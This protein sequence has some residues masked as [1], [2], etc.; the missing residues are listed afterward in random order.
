[1]DPNDGS[2]IPTDLAT[3]S[4]LTDNPIFSSVEDRLGRVNV[5][6]AFAK[7]VRALDV[8]QGA[9]VGVMA[10]WGSGKSSFVNLMRE[11]FAAE[12]TVTTIDF[13]PWMFSG[14]QQLVD[15]FFREIAAALRN[16]SAS[17]FGKVADWLDE[18]GDELGAVAALGG[19]LGSAI[20]ATVRLGGAEY[21]RRSQTG[22]VTQQRQ[23]IADDLKQLPQPIVVVVDDID[24]LGTD[25][26]RDIFKLVRLTASFPNLVYLL[27][28]DRAR[29]EAALDETNVPGRAYLEK[30]VQLSFDLPDVPI[31]LLRQELFGRLDQ[32]MNDTID[33]ARFDPAR[34]SDVFVEI[35]APL[36]T[37]LRD[38]TRFAISLRPTVAALGREVQ[39]VD[40]LALEAVRVFR[41]ELFAQLRTMRIALTETGSAWGSSK[42]DTHQE[43]ITA[44]LASAGADEPLIR[45]LILR[46]FPAATRY[47]D[48]RSYGPG[49]DQTWR[50]QRR[51][52]HIDFLAAY[53]D[54]NEPAE[55]VAFRQAEHFM[56]L[57][58]EGIDPCEYLDSIPAAQ[59]PVVFRALEGFEGEFP[60]EKLVDGLAAVINRTP[61]IPDDDSHGL[62]ALR[63]EMIASRVV[64]RMFRGVEAEVDREGIASAVFTRIHTHSDR[65]RFLLMVGRDEGQGHGLV[66]EVMFEELSQRLISSFVDDGVTAAAREW[67]LWRV[68]RYLAEHDHRVEV[69]VTDAGIVRSVFESLHSQNRAQSGD[70]RYVYLEDVLAWDLLIEVFGSEDRIRNANLSLHAAG[71]SEAL[72]AIVDRYLGGWRPDDQ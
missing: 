70:S 37:S 9:V 28:F 69:D 61:D 8:S 2:D 3:A 24:R 50:R 19:P 68:F 41:P 72:A 46:V 31:V 32:V 49:F 21:K 57:L 67:D 4:P 34:W 66:S 35:V 51:V 23:R 20:A 39:T 10:A 56:E 6:N 43:A 29:V 27:A 22:T 25:E 60:A 18:Y 1:M 54:R 55:L 17:K 7:E 12:P 11:Q 5:A 33:E 38:V 65:L 40:L 71:E 63:G 47:T 48:N 26:I 64:L 52:A 53:L 45:S 62:F 16:E 30:I 44:L 58:V 36:I 14:T 59:L 15:H 13:N 42:N